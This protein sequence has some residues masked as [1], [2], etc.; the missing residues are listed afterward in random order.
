MMRPR[1]I[2]YCSV[3]GAAAMLLPVIFHLFHLGKVFMPMYLPLVTLA[4]FVR[5]F[6]AAL[7]ALVIPPLSGALTGMP[8]FYPP[9]APIMS[10]ELAV[11]GALIAVLHTWRPRVP[12]LVVLVPVL[13]LGRVLGVAL[14]YLSA[15]LMQLP[16]AWVAG[17]S[18]LSGWPGVVLMVIA[19]PAIVRLS[20]A[21]SPAVRPLEHTDDGV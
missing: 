7:T 13:L 6:P 21:V 10:V 20:R 3:C 12:T 19:V 4:F 1:E 5:P 2:A 16:A 9:I 11:M 18:L 14:V 8:P 17:A 15:R